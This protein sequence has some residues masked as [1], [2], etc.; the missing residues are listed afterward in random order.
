MLS[1]ALRWHQYIGPFEQFQHSLLYAFTTYIPGDGRIVAF[2]C[3]LVYF[4]DIDDTTFRSRYVVVAYLEQS[5]K[6][7]LHIFTNIAGFCKHGGVND[8]ERYVQQLGDGFGQQGL[9]GARFAYHDD[10]A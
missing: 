10:I 2:P 5:G 7:A 6:D 1:S 9:T 3:N 8:R 4:I